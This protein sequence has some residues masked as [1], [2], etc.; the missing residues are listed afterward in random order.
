MVNKTK[1]QILRDVFDPARCHH[2]VLAD[3]SDKTQNLTG[4]TVRHYIA[5]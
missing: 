5:C 1:T 2:A 3:N 4:K